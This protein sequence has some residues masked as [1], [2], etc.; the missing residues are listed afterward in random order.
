ML[1]QVE[2]E[3]KYRQWI[4]IISN[5]GRFLTL[6]FI[7]WTI[8]IG[9]QFSYLRYQLFDTLCTASLLSPCNALVLRF[10][11]TIPVRLLHHR[12]K[13]ISMITEELLHFLVGGFL[14]FLVILVAFGRLVVLELIFIIGTC[15]GLWLIF[16]TGCGLIS[17][18]LT[19]FVNLWHK[20]GRL[21]LIL[22]SMYHHV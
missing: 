14:S 10:P 15:F 9:F 2:I 12:L 5:I 16:E 21:V 3:W 18:L 19:V 6:V 13:I 11:D 4:L 7:F 22:L 1:P 20:G 17:I 8:I